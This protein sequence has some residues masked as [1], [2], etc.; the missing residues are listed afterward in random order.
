MTF[1]IQ[2]GEGT[3]TLTNGSITLRIATSFG[4]R[5]LSCAITD[6]PNILATLPDA[7][8]PWRPDKPFHL[9][10]GHRLW[11]APEVPDLTYAPDDEPV[12]VTSEAGTVTV[13]AAATTP[14]PF[15]KTIA[16]RLHQ[17]EPAV[18]VAHSLDYAGAEP[19]EVAPWAITMLRPEGTLL[20]PLGATDG[21]GLQASRSIVLWPY[22][23]LDDPGI[24]IHENL[25]VV[26][27]SRSDP[28]KIGTHGSAGWCAY[29]VDGL[30]FVKTVISAGSGHFAD[31]GATFQGFA[32]AE[33][34][35]LETLGRLR[36]M[37]PGV[38]ANHVETWRL[39]RIDD[40]DPAAPV[41]EAIAMAGLA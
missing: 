38:T 15:H 9:R 23:R 34:C 36:R 22:T 28:T 26:H 39:T 32:R 17:E 1:S 3:V 29:V 30:V 20:L 5:I 4:P 27:G 19:M 40:L 33:F 13:A 2:R 16:L 18:T 31:L 41:A 12:T 21:A 37:Q 24:E 6:A 11:I 8:L 14:S 25:L 7:T 35:E 10:G